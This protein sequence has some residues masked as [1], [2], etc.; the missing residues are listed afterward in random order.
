M[1][2]KKTEEILEDNSNCLGPR[3]LQEAER[4]WIKNAQ[5]DLH[6]RIQKGELT[7]LSPFTDSEGIIRVGGRSDKATVSYESKH[8]ALLPYDHWISLLITRQSHSIGHNGVA[9]TAAKVRRNYWIIRGHDLAKTVKYKCVFC[10][11]MQPK[12]E[13]QLMADLPQVRLAPHTPPFH[14]TSCDY[15]GPYNV[16]I[17]RNKTKKHNGVIFTCLNTRAVHL[18]LAVDC[19]TMDFLQV[20]RRFFAIRG[21]PKSMTSDNGTQLVGAVAELRNMVRGLDAKKLREFSTERGMEWRFITPG[22][23]HQN[24]C[25]EALVKSVKI[26]LKKA[27][28]ETTLTPFELYTLLLEVANLVNERPIGRIPND[29]D[30]GACSYR[31]I[32][33]DITVVFVRNSFVSVRDLFV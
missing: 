8:P 4:Y 9:T 17:G 33:V 18:E 23:P 2:K 15:F 30:D 14:F 11:E 19:S 1:K 32:V 5:K 10:K 16:K 13:T 26:A 21:Y 7:T 27:I 20:L 12:P 28:G 25:A 31:F 6:K 29:P 3:E 24:G 22:A